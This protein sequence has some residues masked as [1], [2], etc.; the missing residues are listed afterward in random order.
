MTSVRAVRPPSAADLDAAW[1]AVLATLPPTPLVAA[2]SLGE[3]VCLKLESLQPTGSFKVRGA[4]AAVRQL[5]AGTEPVT[6][7]AGNAGL[8]L[9]WAGA[10]LGIRSTI[11]VPETA[12]QAKLAALE[13]MPVRLVR[14]GRSY[15]DAERHALSLAAGGSYVSPY[16]DPDVIAGQAT[17]GR[18]LDA[19]L[20]SGP[21]T[22]AC[23]IGGGGLAAGLGLWAAG[24]P[25]ARVIGVEAEPSQAMHA[26]LAAGGVVPIEAGPTIADGLAGN[27]EPGTVT[28]PLVRDLIEDVLAVPEAAIRAA[29]AALVS[30][31]GIVA[32]GA[33]AVPAAAVREGLVTAAEGAIVVVVSGRNIAAATL[34]E[35]LRQS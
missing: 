17:I 35:V 30:E 9:A 6:A 32:E 34:R 13:R 22:V 26:A 2:P 8:G 29:V 24:R 16:N 4:L 10:A 14:Q 5:R 11:V 12:S 19:Q 7:S 3:R 33:G 28:L 21:V 27:I 20:P 1:E 25:G 18:E 23:A 15:E 31:Q